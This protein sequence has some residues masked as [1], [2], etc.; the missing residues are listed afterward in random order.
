MPEWE[1][2]FR[3]R[4]WRR[5]EMVAWSGSLPGLPTPLRLT[6]MRAGDTDV[7]VVNWV[8]PPGDMLLSVD[9]ITVARRDGV[10]TTTS[11]LQATTPP[12]GMEG[13]NVV[14]IWLTSSPDLISGRGI[15]DYQLTVTISTIQGRQL[16]RDFH[17][18]VVAPF[19]P[20]V[21]GPQRLPARGPVPRQLTYSP[22]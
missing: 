4:E 19:G 5:D 2:D 17:M 12:E 10:T 1:Y 18:H 15:I 8:I 22:G 11:D 21:S 14:V 3:E 13:G 20:Q 7:R 6:P 9:N 16:L